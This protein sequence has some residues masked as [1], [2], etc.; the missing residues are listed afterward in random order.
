MC[1]DTFM[2]YPCC[3]VACLNP[4]MLCLKI[5]LHASNHSFIIWAKIAHLPEFL[6]IENRCLKIINFESSKENTM[7]T[8]NIAALTSRFEYLYLLTFYKIVDNL[9]P[10]IDSNLLPVKLTI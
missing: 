2:T 5:H 3:Y 1:P 8:H 7:K 10:V 4:F 6:K 9:V